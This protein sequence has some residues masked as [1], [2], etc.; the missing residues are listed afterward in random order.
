VSRRPALQWV[1]PPPAQPQTNR[2]GRKQQAAFDKK[3][4]HVELVRV[5]LEDIPPGSLMGDQTL[6]DIA[7]GNYAFAHAKPRPTS[8]PNRKERARQ[9]RRDRERARQSR[10]K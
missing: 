9:S 1:G 8:R 7:A 6:A 2:R 5:R 3:L 4:R 10:N